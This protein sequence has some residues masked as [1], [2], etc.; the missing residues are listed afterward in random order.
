MMKKWA[1]ILLSS[2]SLLL[3]IILTTNERSF[4]FCDAKSIDDDDEVSTS[5]SSLSSSSSSSLNFL[6][7]G[8]WGGIDI[9]PYYKIGQKK[10]ALGMGKVA[11]KMNSTFVIG[12][13]DNFYTKG[14]NTSHSNRFQVTFQDIYND[15]SLISI[16]WYI[17]GGNHDH[18]GNISAQIDYTNQLNNTNKRWQFPSLY[19]SHSFISKKKKNSTSTSTSTTSNLSSTT[20]IVY[21]DIILIDTVDLC[22]NIMVQDENEEGYFNPLPLL[23]KSDAAN[24]GEQ[25][26]WIENQLSTSKADY[27]LVGGHYPLYSVCNHGP[28]ETLIKHLRPLLLR[29]N[30]HYMSGHDHCMVHIKEDIVNHI[31]TG[32]GDEC[33]YNASNINNHLNPRH[34]IKWFIS[35][36]NKDLYHAEGGFTSFMAI[37]SHMMVKYHDQDGHVLYTA[38]PILPRVKY[39]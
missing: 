8:D 33:C 1:N 13:G 24:D 18:Y 19:H 31:L 29:Y 28:T 36:E 30:A 20:D 12:L 25:W 14:V 7:I 37:K 38:D 6:A 34:G 17:I 3:V 2:L 39:P 32:M 22:G 9:P 16:P 23:S 5:S 26:K 4:L 35:E 27:L 10:T 11:S 21:V 15:T